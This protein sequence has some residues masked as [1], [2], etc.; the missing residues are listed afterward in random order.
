MPGYGFFSTNGHLEK[1][2]FSADDIKFVLAS[3]TNNHSTG[4]G[5]Q[6]NGKPANNFQFAQHESMK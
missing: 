1:R 4:S 6:N 2:P 5:N 3:L